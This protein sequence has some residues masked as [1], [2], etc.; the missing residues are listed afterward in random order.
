MM[1]GERLDISAR[2]VLSTAAP[3]LEDSGVA[4]LVHC[5]QP[6]YAQVAAAVSNT[7]LV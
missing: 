1:G 4:P 3:K 5:D 7:F 2:N 6:D